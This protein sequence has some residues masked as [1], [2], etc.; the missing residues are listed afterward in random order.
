[1]VTML[2]INPNGGTEVTSSWVLVTFFSAWTFSTCLLLYE[3]QTVV[4]VI[5]KGFL[6]GAAEWLI[7]ILAGFLVF[8][9]AA[10]ATGSGSLV[11]GAASF[12]TG[13]L[14]FFMMLVC[15]A[16]F[17]IVYFWEREHQISLSREQSERTGTWP[18]T[19]GHNSVKR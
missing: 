7:A 5:R 10:S 1:M 13:F 8:G 9:R 2:R 12:I 16:G 19:I 14:S 15:F 11:G 6:L 3:T 4:Q 18:E 17:A